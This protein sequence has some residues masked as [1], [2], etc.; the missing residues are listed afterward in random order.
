MDSIHEELVKISPAVAAIQD[1]VSVTSPEM[2]KH[3]AEDKRLGEHG[4]GMAENRN[5]VENDR[6]GLL[7]TDEYFKLK[8]RV[9]LTCDSCGYFW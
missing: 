6:P 2:G 9:S 8:V 7:P 1:E 5:C 4:K 3:Q